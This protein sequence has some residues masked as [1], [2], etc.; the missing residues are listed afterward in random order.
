MGPCPGTGPPATRPVVGAAAGAAGDGDAAGAGEAAGA[1][2][3][4]AGTTAAEGAGVAAGFGCSLKRFSIRSPHVAKI[5]ERK[6]AE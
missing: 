4:G 3:V 5:G 1:A 6:R 2:P